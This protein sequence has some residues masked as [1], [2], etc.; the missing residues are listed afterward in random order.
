MPRPHPKVLLY[1]VTLHT[2]EVWQTSRP[3]S[4][5]SLEAC[6]AAHPDAQGPSERQLRLADEDGA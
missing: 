1:S 5:G 2:W 4:H 3:I 6:Q